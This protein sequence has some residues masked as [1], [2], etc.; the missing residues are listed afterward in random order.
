MIKFK[1]LL[2]LCCLAGF[3]GPA[4]AQAGL[5]IEAVPAPDYTFGQVLT[6][7]VAASSPAGIRQA[8]LF[9]QVRPTASATAAPA[10]LTSGRIVTG[11]V[12]L[13]LAQSPLPPFA[14]ID[15]WWEV[16]DQAGES[17][18]TPHQ[19]FHYVD[20]RFAWQTLN[21]PPL[22]VYWYEG[23]TAFGQMALS[24]AVTGLTQARL[25][26]GV[27]APTA[28]DLYIYANPA[29]AA[30]ALQPAQHRWAEGRS[31]PVLGLAIVTVAA[32]VEARHDLEREVPHELMHLVLAQRLGAGYPNLPNWLNEGLAVMNQARPDP[33]F[34]PALAKARDTQS[35][36]D[37]TNLCGPFPADATQAQLA[38]AE[39][40]SVVR[41]IRRH[42]PAAALANL[43]DAYARGAICEAGVAQGLGLSQAELE[44]AWQANLTEA[45]PTAPPLPWAV[46]SLVVLLGGGLLTGLIVANLK[47]RRA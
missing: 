4:L 38:Y 2:A 42:F 11:V 7:R 44:Q 30:T 17:A 32:G 12:T 19:A 34:A 40:E 27:A 14:W 13:D 28:M 41:Y 10:T 26:V 25:T 22:T 15:Y 16:K 36:F 6:F 43:L 8:T 23:N 24:A 37:L 20:N 9:Y 3:Y 1:L 47:P 39:S 21:Q 35:L 46:L 45:S 5:Q 33:E 31:D 18:A 29:D